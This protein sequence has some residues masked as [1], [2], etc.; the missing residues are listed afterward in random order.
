[1]L[2]LSYVRENLEQVEQALDR[3]GMDRSLDDFRELDESRRKLLV[4]VE[5]LKR[6][7]NESSKKIGRV[8]QSGADAEPLKTEVR[9]IGDQIAELDGTLESAE[10]ALHEAGPLDLFPSA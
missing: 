10:T 4:E 1:M 9:K 6:T 5:Q 8:I 2:D 3:R 7:R